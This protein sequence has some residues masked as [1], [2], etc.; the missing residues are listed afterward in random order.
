MQL[1]NVWRY[2]FYRN[3]RPKSFS[4]KKCWIRAK[5]SHK[6]SPKLH[7]FKSGFRALSAM[8]LFGFI[9]DWKKKSLKPLK[10]I[11]Y[12]NSLWILWIES[13]VPLFWVAFSTKVFWNLCYY[14]SDLHFLEE[15]YVPNNMVVNRLFGLGFVFG[16]VIAKQQT[17]NKKSLSC[18]KNSKKILKKSYPRCL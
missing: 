4:Y 5:K 18:K 17:G 16:L 2:V 6:N 11:F 9:H 1:N 13:G 12:I 10:R 15:F 14:L 7:S 3:Q 8:L